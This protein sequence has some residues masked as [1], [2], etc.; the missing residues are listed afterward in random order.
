MVVPDGVLNSIPF[1]RLVATEA[2][3]APSVTLA[4]S[5]TVLALLRDRPPQRKTDRPVLAVGGVPYQ[6]IT[7]VNTSS[8]APVGIYDASNAALAAEPG[9]EC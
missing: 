9:G 1:E 3:P 4:P 8:T 6:R 7:G 5:A 2:N